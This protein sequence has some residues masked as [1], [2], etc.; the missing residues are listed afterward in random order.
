MEELTQHL[1]DRWRELM[2]RG[3]TPGD[4]ARIARTEFNGTRLKALLAT[5]RQTHWGEI[6]PPGPA[7]AF[8]LDS[9]LIDLRHALRA[10]RATPSFTIGALLVLALGTGA[11][12]AIFSVVDAV[13]L[14]PLPFPDPDR[15]V[16]VGVRVDAAVGGAGGPQRSGSGGPQGTPRPLGAIPGA[17]PPEPDALMNVTSQEYLAWADQQQV[18][19]SMAAIVD[20]ADTVLQRPDAELEIVKGQRVTASFFDVLLARPLL[21]A[22]FTSQNELAGSDRVVVVS[23][24]LWQRYSAAIPQ[25]LAAL[26]CSMT[27]PTRLSG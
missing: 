24:R 1:D 26:L 9:L 21:G 3:E 4:A 15:I 6:P 2:A 25:P 12:T 16:A 18:F 7:R 14:R 13:A 19:E 23:H 20:T 22:A 17:K 10:L 5:L 11:T 27:T 8:S